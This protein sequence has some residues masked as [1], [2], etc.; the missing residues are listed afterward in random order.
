M[1]L[2]LIF[3][4][5]GVGIIVAVLNMLLKKADRDEYAMV[6]TIAGLIVVLAMIINEIA[7][8]FETVKTV[9]GF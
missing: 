2:D 5:A 6:V 9:F 3:R 8:L 4:I 7:A 1:E